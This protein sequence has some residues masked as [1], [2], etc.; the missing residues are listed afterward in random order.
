MATVSLVLV[1]ALLGGA[2]TALLRLP[3]MVG[4]LGAG[5]ALH[6]AGVP[7]PDG[8]EVVADLGVTLLLFGIGLKFDAGT[9]LRREVWLPGAV[10]MVL[11][12]AA[13]TLVLGVL[14]LVGPDMVGGADLTTLALVGLTLAFSSTV[15]VVKL[16]EERGVES[17]VVGRTAIGIL[18]VQDLAA[19]AFISVAHG[20]APSPWAVLLVLLVP[21]A[22]VV[23]QAMQN[24]GHQE[25]RPLLGVVLAL[26]PGYTLFEA[27]GLKG[28]LGALVVGVLV[29]AHP[30]AAGLAR[31][32]LAPKDLLLVGF[33]LSIGFTGLPGIDHLVVAAVLLLLLPLKV[34]GFALLLSLTRLRRRTAV[35][36]GNLLGNYSEFALIAA[37]ALAPAHLDEG[38]LTALATAVA[39]SMVLSSVVSRRQ[40]TVV[41]RLRRLLPRVPVDQL[42][43]DDR[44]VDVGDA[45]AIVLGM[46]RVGRSAYEQL[47]ERFGLRVVGVELDTDRATWM[48]DGG[49]RVVHGDAT[50]PEFWGRVCATEVDIAVLAMPFHGHNLTALDQ[51]R[52]GGFAGTVAVVAQQDADLAEARERG[53]HAGFQLYDGAGTELA[54]RAAVAAGLAEGEDER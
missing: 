36:T 14:A 54:H 42:H 29:G 43:P 21:G 2:L 18:V 11:T 8:L 12:A 38:W 31:S 5:F 19:V 48:R 13:A 28:D 50:D 53:V 15:L 17:S 26:V 34:Y 33:F 40:E 3:P 7:E 6:A 1:A 37:V 51:L 41:T 49:L 46:G 52:E 27:V 20:R 39:L 45:Q 44:P 30:G 9:L 22:W 25:L 4:F 32:L 24:V 10:H 47:T 35:L 23:G 16:L